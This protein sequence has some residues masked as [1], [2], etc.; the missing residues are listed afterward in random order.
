MK[1]VNKAVSF[2]LDNPEQRKLYE[3]VMKRKNISDYL[4]RIIKKDMEGT[5]VPKQL[6]QEHH[7]AEPDE[8]DDELMNKL[9]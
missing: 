5:F 4:K 9:I 2:N 8:L 6:N 1:I 3:H 7:P